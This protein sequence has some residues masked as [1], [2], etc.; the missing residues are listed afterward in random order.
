MT[1]KG[2]R[3]EQVSFLPSL[4]SPLRQHP[5][6]YFVCSNILVVSFAVLLA[7]LATH[8]RTFVHPLVRVRHHLHITRY[9]RS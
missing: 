7:R 9:W 1:L 3:A 2:L 5:K 6:R 4:P 8:T